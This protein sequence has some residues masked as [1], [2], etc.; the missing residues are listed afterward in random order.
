MNKI[1]HDATVVDVKQNK[2]RI[3][4]DQMSACNVCSAAESCGIHKGKQ[5][6]FEIN[7]RKVAKS[8]KVGDSIVVFTP[9]K[10]AKQAIRNL[11]KLL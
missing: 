5:K 11:Q 3:R 9:L 4:I 7:D 1:K 10:T 2:V 6:E 8:V